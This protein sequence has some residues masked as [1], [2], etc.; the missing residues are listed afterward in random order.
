MFRLARLILVLLSSALVALP[1]AAQ[2]PAA[3]PAKP[4]RIVVPYGA[5]GPIDVIA[6]KLALQL[7]ARLGQ[8]VIVENK[9]GADTIIGSDLV[10]NTA[11]DGYVVLMTNISASPTTRWWPRKG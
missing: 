4:I 9:P 3:Y 6:R 8:N 5:G 10:A 7:G 11:P 1:G 2:V